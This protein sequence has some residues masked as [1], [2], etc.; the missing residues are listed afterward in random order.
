MYRVF[1]FQH[2]FWFAF[3]VYNTRHKRL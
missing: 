1:I 2:F 3:I